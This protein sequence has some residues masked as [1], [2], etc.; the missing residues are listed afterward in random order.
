MNQD[1]Q[2]VESDDIEEIKRQLNHFQILRNVQKN[3]IQKKKKNDNPV[4][5][6]ILKRINEKIEIFETKKNEIENKIC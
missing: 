4:E 5:Q 1:L 2:F 6:E 3:W